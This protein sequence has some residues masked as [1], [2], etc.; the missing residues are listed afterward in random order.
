MSNKFIKLPQTLV[1]DGIEFTR[2]KETQTAYMYKYKYENTV[3]F[4]VFSKQSI[5]NVEQYPCE[6][7]FGENAYSFNYENEAIKKLNEL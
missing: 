5:S 3:I 1:I 7:D 4:E 2:V 6:E